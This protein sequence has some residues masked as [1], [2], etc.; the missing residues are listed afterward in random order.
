MY[1]RDTR[2][3]D[4]CVDRELTDPRVIDLLRE[5][6]AGMHAHSPAESV[7]AL[8]LDGLRRPEITFLTAG[9][10]NCS[11]VVRSR[12]CRPAPL[13]RPGT[14]KSSPCAPARAT[15][16]KALPAPCEITTA[17]AITPSTVATSAST[18]KIEVSEA[19]ASSSTRARR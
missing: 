16:A 4:I 19:A 14:A 8:D 3:I 17:N 2:P 10:I 11:P 15:C 6:L 7:H 12:S 5:H 18:S 13:A 9:M 1:A